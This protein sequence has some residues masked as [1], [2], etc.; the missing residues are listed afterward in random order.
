[1]GRSRVYY[2]YPASANWQHN[3]VAPCSI[4]PGRSGDARVVRAPAGD[5][6]RPGDDDKQEPRD[7]RGSA[8]E[9]AEAQPGDEQQRADRGPGCPGYDP[10]RADRA[11]AAPIQGRAAADART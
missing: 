7:P 2:T 1:M 3:T 11:L 5:D 9:Q 6:E 8:G 4:P 10:L